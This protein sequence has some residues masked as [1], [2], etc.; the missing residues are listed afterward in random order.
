[1]VEKRDLNLIDT[2]LDPSVTNAFFLGEI[3]KLDGIEAE[4]H[5]I[6]ESSHDNTI[7]HRFCRGQRF[8]QQPEIL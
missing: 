7:L 6:L 4:V 1:M 5:E 3:L 8:H 2:A